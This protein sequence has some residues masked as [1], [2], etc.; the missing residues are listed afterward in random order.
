[1]QPCLTW[2]AGGRNLTIPS[3]T[4]TTFNTTSYTYGT[5]AAAA[6]R[7]ALG[8]TTLATTTPA[9]N[10]ATFLA[11]P[12]S[13]N[14]A[15]AVTGETGSGSLVFGTSP[16]IDAPTISGSAAF[17]STTRPTSAGTG[18]PAATSL[19]NQSDFLSNHLFD[20]GRIIY[21]NGAGSYG[22]AGS[23]SG[24]SA[25]G[26]N[27][28]MISGTDASGYG[29]V[30]R[31]SQMILGYVFSGV[32]NI[33]ST[34]IPLRFASNI[35]LAFNERSSNSPA[36]RG[37]FGLPDVARGSDQSATTGRGFGWEI[38]WSTTNSRLEIKLWAHDGTNYVSSSGVELPESG[39]TAGAQTYQIIAGTNGAGVISLWFARCYASSYSRPSATPNIT[40]S[41]GPT[42]NW[43]AN[44]NCPVWSIA[45]HST[46]AP[47]SS[48]RFQLSRAIIAIDV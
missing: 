47:S 13:A 37:G 23:G 40:L 9:A 17:T 41:G 6:H 4:A 11:T 31:F 44:G 15:A 8:L 2:S 48:S 10:V 34:N 14:L 30:K 12:T 26:D 33:I 20:I 38:Y 32:N 22:N 24:A 7:T 21:S 25:A 5:G 16:T 19:I 36:V 27:D 1:M 42:T 46:S 43:Y 28:Q 29:R 18:T 45:N 39:A 3:G 35:G